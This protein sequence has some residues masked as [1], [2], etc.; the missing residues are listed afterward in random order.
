MARSAWTGVATRDFTDVDTSPAWTPALNRAIG[1]G[2]RA[3]WRLPA[4]R[5][6]TLLPG[7]TAVSDLLVYMYWSTGAKEAAE[8]RTVFSKPGGGTPDRRAAVLSARDAVRRPAGR[9]PAV[10]A[11]SWSRTA[12]RP[13]LLGLPTNGPSRLDATSWIRD[14]SAGRADLLPGT[15]P[16]SPGCRVTPG[17]DN[18]T[19]ATSRFWGA[20][21]RADDRLDPGA[22]CCSPACGTSARLIRRPCCSPGSLGT[23]VYPG[24]ERRGDGGGEQLQ[25]QRVPPVGMLRAGCSRWAP[26]CRRCQREW[27]GL[28]QPGRHCRR[29]GWRASNMSSVSPG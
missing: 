14:G 6:E 20:V 22:G 13:G 3:P 1:L 7:P 16:R 4:G 23:G 19:F 5:Y 27:G 25:V 17:I 2:P 26:R 10:R 29:C 24:G 18:L 15:R 28:L 9:G 12:V 11:V 21:A 8:G